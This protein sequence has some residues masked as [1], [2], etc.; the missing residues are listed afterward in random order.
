MKED[1]ILSPTYEGVSSAEENALANGETGRT[2]LGL[3][4]AA[5]LVVGVFATMRGVDGLTGT[6]DLFNFCFLE[7]G[8]ATLGFISGNDQILVGK[9]TYEASVSE[10]TA[11]SSKMRFFVLQ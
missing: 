11:A 2:G 4:R 7:G 9:R 10:K 8:R 5:D 1:D 6:R 3:E